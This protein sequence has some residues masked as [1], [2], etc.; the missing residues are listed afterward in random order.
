VSDSPLGLLR[1]ALSEEG[2]GVFR[3]LCSHSNPS[4]TRNI[5]AKLRKRLKRIVHHIGVLLLVIY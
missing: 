1:L 5:F 2:R 4:G 3:E